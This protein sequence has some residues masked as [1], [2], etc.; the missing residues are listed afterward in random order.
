ML[1]QSLE[2][3]AVPRSHSNVPR[4]KHEA[5]A[6]LPWIIYLVTSME[7]L[8]EH[9]TT[10]STNTGITCPL[11]MS[12]SLEAAG[13]S[14]MQG[15]AIPHLSARPP[16]PKETTN[17]LLKWSKSSK[18]PPRRSGLEHTSH[19][20]RLREW[21]SFSLEKGRFWGPSEQPPSTCEEEVTVRTEPSFV[22]RCRAEREN[23]HKLKQERL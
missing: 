22:L 7:L 6:D 17:V 23:R 16:L 11:S 8:W 19:V 3:L 13:C 10:L 14:R 5:P 1:R 12:S 15:D 21:C 4:T 20:Q 18:E 2:T 9:L